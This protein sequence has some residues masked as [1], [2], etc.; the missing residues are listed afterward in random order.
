M[1]ERFEQIRAAIDETDRELVALVNTRLALVRELWSL[2]RELGLDRVD[3]GREA[4]I[5]AALA[6]ANGGPLSAAGLDELVSEL[7]ALT[8]RELGRA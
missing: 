4:A 6:A 7:L 8:K 3:P 5:R 2:K 1:S